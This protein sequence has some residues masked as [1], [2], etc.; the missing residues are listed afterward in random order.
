MP[1]HEIT[2]NVAAGPQAFGDGNHPTT[3]GVLVALEAVDTAL[4]TPRIACDIGAGSGILALTIAMKFSC[5]VVA[6]D[7]EESAVV[8]MTANAQANGIVHGVLPG[9]SSLLAVRADGFAHPQV[10]DHAPY[11]LIVM[12]ILAEPLL[13]LARTAEAHLASGGALIISG[14]MTHQESVIREAY[15]RLGLELMRRLTIA[16][17]VTLCWGKP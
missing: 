5:P 17:W 14:I 6:V 4:F 1:M 11:D 7:R 3:R 12:N 2:L 8:T 10:A 16:D 15:E 13:K 9:H